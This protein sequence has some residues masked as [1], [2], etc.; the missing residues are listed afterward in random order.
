MS[1]FSYFL[2][3]VPRPVL[4]RALFTQNGASAPSVVAVLENSLVG[5]PTWARSG[6][7]VYTVTL[8]GAFPS[9]Q[10]FCQFAQGPVDDPPTHGII[11]TVSRTSNDVVTIRSFNIA[12]TPAEMEHAGG[13]A[14]LEI[15]V[16]S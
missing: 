13:A 4:Y 3:D 5:T 8:T 16:Y 6:V 2:D 10:T 9:N 15:L 12:G 14:S 7:G 11:C 1:D